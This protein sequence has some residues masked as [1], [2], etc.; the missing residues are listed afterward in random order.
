MGS[1]PSSPL[2]L[3]VVLRVPS[4][5]LAYNLLLALVPNP[6]LVGTTHVNIESLFP[7]LDLLLFLVLFLLL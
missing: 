4:M 7:L 1:L 5:L 6:L 2:L 3:T